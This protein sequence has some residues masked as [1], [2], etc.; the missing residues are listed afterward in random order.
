MKNIR[1]SII[2]VAMLS[3]ILLALTGCGSKKLV[4]T[5]STD[6][7]GVKYEETIEV[8]FKND[9]ANEIVWTLDFDD[10]S[11]AETYSSLYE[12]VASEDGFKI[13][14]DGKKVVMTLDSE[15]F[16]KLQDGSDSDDSRDA[17]KKSLE[18]EGYTVK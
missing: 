11:F 18:D 5:K 4:A 12:S 16:A 8:S 3:A 13:E 2:L 15:A 9:K 17:V 10:E 7:Y 1:K 14:R 6:Q